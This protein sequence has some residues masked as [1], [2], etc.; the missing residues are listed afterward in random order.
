MM[1]KIVFALALTSLVAC[2][3]AKEEIGAESATKK[4]TL[5][6]VNLNGMSYCRMVPTGGQL[7]QPAG[8]REHCIS[9]SD[10]QKVIDNG[11]T[12]FGNPPQRGTYAVKGR[13]V[14][15]TL[16][17]VNGTSVEKFTL[18][19]DTKTITSEA[20]A[21]LTQKAEIALAN[22]KYCRIVSGG[23][24]IAK[25]AGDREHCIKFVDGQ[26]VSDNGSTFFGNPPEQGTY[27]VSGKVITLILTSVTGTSHKETYTLSAD[28]KS[29]TG[30][31]A[32][33][34]NLKN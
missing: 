4:D 22:K 1:K 33:I 10:S 31:A 3:T 25:P 2:G 20:G 18:S 11:S 26:K 21:I 23:D 8:Q 16:N 32:A 6:S 17:S 34:L 15:L 14:T 13:V 30:E 12:F 28:S 27:V 9:F 24:L 19:T 7:G 5:V 29:I